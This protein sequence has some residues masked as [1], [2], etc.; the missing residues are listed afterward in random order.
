MKADKEVYFSLIPTGKPVGFPA[1]NFMT[2]AE[3]LIKNEI[4][5]K[6]INIHI[7]NIRKIVSIY[8]TDYEKIEYNLESNDPTQ[9]TFSTLRF[10]EV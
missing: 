6:N 9:N 10:F 1:E 7:G 4:P 2:N 8:I 5:F 3:W